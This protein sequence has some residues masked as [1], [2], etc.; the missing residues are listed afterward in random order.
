M[1]ERTRFFIKIYISHTLFSKGW[2]FLCVRGEWRQGRNVILTQ[3]LLTIA[4]LFLILAGVAQPW[5]TE[6]LKPSVCRWLSIRHLVPNW[7]QLQMTQAVCVLVICLIDVHLL[8]LF[9]RLF[10][11]VHLLIDGSVEG[12]YVTILKP[13]A[14]PV[15]WAKRPQQPCS[16]IY[17]DFAGPTNGRRFSVVVDANSKWPEIFPVLNA[18]IRSTITIL[19][20]L[21]QLT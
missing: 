14:T 3:V 8:P 1:N 7:F 10:T 4:A 6:G 2:C 12:Q 5:V 13:S 9:F 18:N 15:F 21:I 20:R 19:K 17:V 16:R 11:Q